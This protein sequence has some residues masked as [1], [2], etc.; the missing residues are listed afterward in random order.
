VT[1]CQPGLFADA[2]CRFDASFVGLV[3][4]QLDDGAWV[5]HQ[6]SW[7]TGD[8]R[9]FASLRETSVWREQQRQM[10]DSV[11]DVPRLFGSVPTEGRD[12]ALIGDMAR[13]ISDRYGVALDHVSVSLYRGGD[14]SV[15]W[16]GDQIAREVD[17]AHVVTVSLGAPRRF[18]LRRVSGPGRRTFHLGWGDLM[19]MGGSCQRTWQHCVPKVP[20]ADP[21]MVLM[22]RPSAVFTPPSAR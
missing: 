3:R 2:T 12:G 20:R 16:H 14:D 11:L 6:P 21:R 13:A 7:L 17:T 18:L 1:A 8:A 19:V 4:H 5:D 9:L 22:F 15:A 10:Y